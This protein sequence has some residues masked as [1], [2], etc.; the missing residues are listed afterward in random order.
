M[1]WID[2]GILAFISI[3]ALRGM[4]S[5]LIRQVV[6]LASVVIG[7]V[8]ASNLYP[9]LTENIDFVVSNLLTR[10]LIA[11]AAIFFGILVLGIIAEQLLRTVASLLLLGPLDAIGGLAFG[12]VRFALIVAFILYAV[13]AFPAV[14]GMESQLAESTIAPYFLAWL[15]VLQ[16]LLPEGFRAAIDGVGQGELPNLPIPGIPR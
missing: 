15:P 14:P 3:G 10:Q 11:F 5:G 1:A 6:G 2:L 8:V 4:S 13:T 12:V 16:L 7:G 9:R